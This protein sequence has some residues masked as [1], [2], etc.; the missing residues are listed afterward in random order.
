M[1]HIFFN[2][3]LVFRTVGKNF[4]WSLTTYLIDLLG[5]NI[6]ILEN[7]KEVKKPRYFD[8]DTIFMVG[9]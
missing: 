6:H 3:P 8:K 5:T 9:Q 7:K 1:L 2:K 4:F